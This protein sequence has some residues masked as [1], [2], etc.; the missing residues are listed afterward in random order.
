M[1]N[2]DRQ[3]FVQMNS[4]LRNHQAVHGSGS[5]PPDWGPNRVE[6]FKGLRSRFSQ[7]TPEAEQPTGGFFESLFGG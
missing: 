4:E 5:I 6:L 7:K 2:S 1:P 3:V